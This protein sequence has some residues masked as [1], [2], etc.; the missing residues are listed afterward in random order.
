MTKIVAIL[1]LA[2]G[3]ILIYR[4]FASFVAYSK[5]S[6]EGESPSFSLLALPGY[7]GI[8]YRR[9]MYSDARLVNL[10]RRISIA[11][12]FLVALAALIVFLLQVI[13]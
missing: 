7:L 5:L 8:M 10:I 13:Q 9:R 1:A 4:T 6:R 3:L 2:C 11:D 12:G